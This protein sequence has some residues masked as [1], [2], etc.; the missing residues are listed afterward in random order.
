MKW[1]RKM[2]DEEI[3]EVRDGTNIASAAS[4]AWSNKYISTAYQK[5]I[6]RS[7]A[8]MR[9]GGLKIT[10]RWVNAAFFRPVHADRVGLIYTRTYSDLKGITTAMDARISR[11]LSLGIAEGRGVKSI[12]KDLRD[13]VKGIGVARSKVIARTEIIRAHSEATLN[14]YEEAGL[15]DVEV[16]AEFTTAGDNRVCQKCKSLEAKNPYKLKEAR[17]LI[18]VHP[19]CR[20]AWIPVVKNIAGVEF[21]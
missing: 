13:E 17:G 20:C 19:N 8:Q 10:D 18:P 11:T 9:K 5:G 3:L 4:T 15:E 16:E 21:L 2:E 12:A 14:T 7:A 6:A 1:L